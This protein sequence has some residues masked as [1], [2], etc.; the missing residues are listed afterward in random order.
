MCCLS[1]SIRGK[2]AKDDGL[3]ITLVVRT[4]ALMLV[5]RHDNKGKHDGKNVTMLLNI[6]TKAILASVMCWNG[7]MTA[8]VFLT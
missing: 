5:M 3:I 6:N 7:M 2:E 4:T 8:N 1:P